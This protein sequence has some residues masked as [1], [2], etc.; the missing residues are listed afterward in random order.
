VNNLRSG[1]TAAYLK[2]AAY[3]DNIASWKAE[4]RELEAKIVE[5][6]RM[7]KHYVELATKVSPA[8]IEA[9]ANEGLRLCS[10]AAM[11]QA[12]AQ[13]IDK[14]SNLLKL[15]LSQLKELYRAFQRS[16]L[17]HV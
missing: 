15:K 9:K 17:G 3:E 6:E 1:V 11:L 10:N 5:E 2:A 14:D 8:Q 7:Q 13:R 12:T 4:I 16:S